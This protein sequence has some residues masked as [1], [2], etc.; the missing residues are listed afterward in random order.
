VAKK[1][2]W[3]PGEPNDTWTDASLKQYLK[4]KSQAMSREVSGKKEKKEGR[5]KRAT[6]IYKNPGL[7]IEQDDV[8][9]ISIERAK[10]E[11]KM[12]TKID[13]DG[14]V[15]ITRQNARKEL[16]AI[17]NSLVHEF[18]SVIGAGT[19]RVAKNEKTRYVTGLHVWRGS[20]VSK[21][22]NMK[23]VE[24][25]EVWLRCQSGRSR[26]KDLRESFAILT[27][28]MPANLAVAIEQAGCLYPRGSFA[29]DGSW[30]GTAA[31]TACRQSSS[32]CI[33]GFACIK[34]AQCPNTAGATDGERTWGRPRDKSNQV[35]SMQSAVH[36]V[37]SGRERCDGSFEAGVHPN[38]GCL[39]LSAS[40][41]FSRRHFDQIRQ[42][43]KD[44]KYLAAAHKIND[45]R[46]MEYE[47]HGKTTPGNPNLCGR[48][49]KF[50]V[51]LP[52][53]QVPAVA[54]LAS[55][56]Q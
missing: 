51:V 38:T 34:I 17:A 42:G 2:D 50:A 43:L 20:R 11:K 4:S 29:A 35:D 23:T 47:R 14:W 55:Q 53:K 18:K 10:F 28:A 52:P 24:F 46:L 19:G 6:T 27:V 25:E 36:A 8:K 21:T 45:E 32:G 44:S 7:V 41:P 37:Y 39:P 54:L 22:V 33:H 31:Y 48:P 9:A 30:L 40:C 3:P 56:E 1:P 49:L 15:P 5:L 13:G 16:P 12:W 26:G